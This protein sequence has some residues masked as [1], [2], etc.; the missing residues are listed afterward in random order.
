[1]RLWTPFADRC[2]HC[3]RRRRRRYNPLKFAAGDRLL[4]A[5]GNRILDA[6]GNVMLDDGAG[7]TCCCETVPNCICTQLSAIITFSGVS[8]CTSCQTN[9]TNPLHSAQ[10][11][12]SLDGTYT[13]PTF[14]TSGGHC[15]SQLLTN[16][17]TFT[18][19]SD[20]TCSTVYNSSPGFYIAAHYDTI[21]PS[22]YP[23]DPTLPQWRISV[24]IPGNGL[25]HHVFRGVKPSS[26]MTAPFT[27]NN[28]I[29]CGSSSTSGG[30]AF[31]GTATVTL[32]CP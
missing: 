19:Y 20:T 4:D 24:A 30:L 2:G 28:A 1:M 18:E 26:F 11:S 27:V 10:A 6:S 12:G 16:N 9:Q 29:T 25:L 17:L 3:G 21:T 31:G 8:I 22:D 14:T 23:G 13:M 5:S 32:V 7:N 15:F